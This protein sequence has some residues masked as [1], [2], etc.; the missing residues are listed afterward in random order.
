MSPIVKASAA[1]ASAPAESRS[2]KRVWL[3]AVLGLVIAVAA[4]AGAWTLAGRVPTVVLDPRNHDLYFASDTNRV[5]ANMVTR[6][7]NHWRTNVHP[8][9]SIE[10]HPA[11]IAV[12]ALMGADLRGGPLSPGAVAVGRVMSGLAAGI[13]AGVFFALLR[14]ALI[15]RIDAIIFCLLAAVSAFSLFWFSIPET[16][17]WGSATIL[18][19]LLLA[20]AGSH[21]PLSVMWYLGASVLTLSITTTNWMVGV[22]AMWSRFNWRKTATWT[23]VALFIVLA[24]A[25]VQKSLFPSSRLF[26]WPGGEQHFVMQQQN[27]GPLRCWAS[28]FAHTVIMPEVTTALDVRVP[29]R[30][31]ANAKF[32]TCVSH[33]GLGEDRPG[34]LGPA[35]ARR[36][37]CPGYITRPLSTTIHARTGAAGA[38]GAAHHLRG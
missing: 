34:V 8:L 31:P 37:V 30:R 17:P 24:L 12:A 13:A 19:A 20:A 6:Q 16:Y 3:D 23:A 27:G 32:R 18:A 14:T 10:L 28:F 15:R 11:F 33:R 1:P 2:I 26:I 22:L 9:F 25:L 38:T 35:P 29:G 7:S 5:H 4:A 36:R 21:K